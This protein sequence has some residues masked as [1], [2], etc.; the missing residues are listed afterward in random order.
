MK[1][2]Y[3]LLI[4]LTGLFACKKEEV[5]VYHGGDRVQF[6]RLSTKPYSGDLFYSFGTKG[7]KMIDTMFI[8]VDITGRVANFD[9]EINIEIIS[10]ETTAVQGTDFDFGK[11]VIPAGKSKGFVE[12]I[13][14]R[15]KKLETEISVV[16]FRI[17]TSAEFMLGIE[18]QL[19]SKVSF[20]D[21]LVKPVSW[22]FMN[23][24]TY[25]VTKHKFV[26]YHLGFPE[27]N[28]AASGV[29][30]DIPNYIF[31]GSKF[32]LFLVQLRSL[33]SDLNAGVLKPDPNDP[34]IY[35]LKDENGLPVVFP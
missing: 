35:P 5:K 13:L 20:Y 3:L 16:S 8:P 27:I 18:K 4:L 7:K 28:R 19:K 24:G 33:L 2:T 29:A 22:D 31:A 26:L 32:P 11:K 30:E 15:T 25:S 21:Y 34:F 14:K 9:R 6:T 10:G 23:F 1:K 12:L 17:A